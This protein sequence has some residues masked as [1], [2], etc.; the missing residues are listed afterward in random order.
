MA[1]TNHQPSC[2]C[3]GCKPNQQ[4]QP[5]TKNIPGLCE[6]LECPVALNPFHP[7]IYNGL[8]SRCFKGLPILTNAEYAESMKVAFDTYERMSNI[9]NGFR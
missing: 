5:A 9:G 1:S 6:T 4:A 8:C 2:I 3:T 7:V